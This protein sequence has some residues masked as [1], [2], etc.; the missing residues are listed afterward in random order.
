[1]VY[2]DTA[3]AN[4]QECYYMWQALQQNQVTSKVGLKMESN[5]NTP[6]YTSIAPMLNFT[7]TID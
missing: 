6:V 7:L 1:M 2:I 5:K 4:K 3:P